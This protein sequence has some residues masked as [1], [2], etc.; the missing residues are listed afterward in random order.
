MTRA[1][2]LLELFSGS[3][4]MS[5][6]AQ[7]LGFLTLTLDNDESRK[8][9]IAADIME[10][11]YQDK[12]WGTFDMIHASI[13]CEQ[14]SRCNTSG[15]PRLQAARAV[16]A[17][18]REI[19]D[20]HRKLNP[21]LVI[22]IENP[23]TSLLSAEAAVRG[24][25]TTDA[26]YCCYGFPYRKDTRFFHN[27]KH[28]SLAECCRESCFWKDGGHP[29]N[30]QHAPGAMRSAIPRCLCL[31]I[32]FS[33]CQALGAPCAARVALRPLRSADIDS[34][35]APAAAP[36]SSSSF[37]RGS[38]NAQVSGAG[39]GTRG[40]NE[41]EKSGALAKA[42]GA[43]GRPRHPR[44]GLLCSFC[45]SDDPRPRWYHLTKPPILCSRCYRRQ[46]SLSAS[47]S[48]PLLLQAARLTDG[49]EE[50]GG[51]AALPSSLG[52]ATVAFEG[53]DAL[54]VSSN[55]NEAAPPTECVC[56]P[57]SLPLAEEDAPLQT[58]SA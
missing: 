28:L 36:S 32:L 17:R 53:G 8:P 3:K 58:F 41:N 29:S 33:A 7:S 23:K 26:S 1:P 56:D 51:E 4:A 9:D 48:P 18:T 42:S 46:K 34:A 19:L 22:V 39:R 57:R 38:P 30:V 37:D 2:R 54:L 5:Q 13:P 11:N 35:E 55:E 14:F 52:E 45:M 40:S 16:A 31:S 27:L 12:F 15:R 50:A 20:H 6:T 44:A 21:R 10:W 49:D 25:R 47:S 24:L 43:K